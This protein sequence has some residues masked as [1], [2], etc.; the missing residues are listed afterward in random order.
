VEGELIAC[1]GIQDVGW[2]DDSGA[3]EDERMRGYE[4]EQFA[5]ST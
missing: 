2:V 4:V 1:E 5:E 3:E